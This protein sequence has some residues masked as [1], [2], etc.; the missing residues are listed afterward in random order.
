MKIRLILS[1]SSIKLA[2]KLSKPFSKIDSESKQTEF[3]GSNI[4][5][6]KLSSSV[7]EL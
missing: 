6:S 1:F 4:C 7:S 2:L 5:V 3:S